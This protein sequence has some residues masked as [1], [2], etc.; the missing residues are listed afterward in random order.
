MYDLQATQTCL[1][2][3]DQDVRGEDELDGIAQNAGEGAIGVRM[4]RQRVALVFERNGSDAEETADAYAVFGAEPE[5]RGNV[6]LV[7]DKTPTE[8]E[9]ATVGD[10]LRPTT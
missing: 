2:Q 5:R 8:E 9:R 10:C 1:V 3:A 6:L 4:G 7:W